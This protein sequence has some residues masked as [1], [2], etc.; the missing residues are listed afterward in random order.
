MYVLLKGTLQNFLVSLRDHVEMESDLIKKYPKGSFIWGL[1]AMNRLVSKGTKVFL[2][3]NKAEDFS[4][5]VVLEGEVVDVAELKEKYWPEGEWNYYVALKVLRIPS[6]VLKE[7]DPRKWKVIDLDKMRELGVKLLPG[8]QKVDDSV[9]AKIEE[10][11][12]KL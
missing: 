9:G 8:V 3:V 5:G 6:S 12:G 10:L 11:L 7:K 2:Y 1:R 4:G